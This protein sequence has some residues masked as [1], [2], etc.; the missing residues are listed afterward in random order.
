MAP[1][2]FDADGL[3]RYE[4][5]GWRAY[6][7][8]EWPRLLRMTIGICQAQFGIPFP[9]SLKAAYHI[10][11]ASVAWAPV[12][13]DEVAVLDQLEKFYT[14]AARHSPLDFD[15]LRAAEW[16]F[17]YFDD[18]RRLAGKPYKAELLE[19]LVQL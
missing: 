4:T 7:D 3:A 9:L 18:H 12:D 6:Y 2:T 8:R 5:A 1:R 17:R 15:P 13:H 19:T 10:V 11:R 14:L 16:E